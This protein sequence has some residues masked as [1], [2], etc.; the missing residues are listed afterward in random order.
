MGYDKSGLKTPQDYGDGWGTNLGRK[1]TAQ[2]VHENFKWAAL[3]GVAQNTQFYK[4]SSRPLAKSNTARTTIV[5]QILYVEI[6]GEGYYFSGGDFD[7]DTTGAWDDTQYQ[8]PGNRAGKDFYIYAGVPSSGYAADIVLSANATVP[9]GYTADTSRKIGGFHCLCA[10]IGTSTYGYVN[11]TDDIALVDMAYESHSI[12][13]TQHWLEG[14]AQGDVLPFSLWD[15]LHRPVSSPEG[16]VYDP[17]SDVWVDIYLASASS[18]NLKSIYNA[19]TADGGNGWHQYRLQQMFAR[20]RKL[21]PRQDEFV[22]FSLGS[23]QGVNISG[24]ADSGTTGGHSATDGKRIVSLIGVEDATGVLW[25]W[26]REAGATN[27]VGSSW[28]NAYD[29]NDS[30]VAGQHYEA[31]NRARFGGHWGDGSSCGSRGS[32]WSA[33]ALNLASSIGG[34][35]VAEPLGRR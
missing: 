5:M 31:P 17:G 4:R 26:G 25:Q 23:P 30:N 16:M 3:F 20:A 22:S 14:Y 33:P 27:D 9:S 11:S 24:S 6:N 19:T 35:G 28:A 10:D 18:G 13:G 7:L 21:L 12:S 29:G 1:L 2:E 15:L 34:R 8:T 32:Y